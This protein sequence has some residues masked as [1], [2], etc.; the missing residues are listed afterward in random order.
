M[1]RT[2]PSKRLEGILAGR[3]PCVRPVG[4][5]SGGWGR[6]VWWAHKKD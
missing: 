2:N 5:A 3:A 1:S 4:G 6:R